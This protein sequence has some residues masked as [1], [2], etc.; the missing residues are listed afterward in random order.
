MPLTEKNYAELRGAI[1]SG[2]L[3]FF[4]ADSHGTIRQKIERWLVMKFTSSPFTHCGMV[5]IMGNRRWCVDMTTKG[6]APRLLS[7]VGDFD[8]VPLPRNLQI[9]P[10]TASWICSKFG[11]LNYSRW[12]AILGGLGLLPDGESESSMCAEFVADVLEYDGYKDLPDKITPESLYQ[13]AIKMKAKEE[14]K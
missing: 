6:L 1:R 12:R 8:I 5:L 7:T 11:T 10:S 13:W 9:K 3:L 4:R 14:S 2:D